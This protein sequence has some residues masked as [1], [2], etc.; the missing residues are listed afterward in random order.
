ML[1]RPPLFAA[2]VVLARHT[3]LAAI[4]STAAPAFLAFESVAAAATAFL[5]VPVATFFAVSTVGR[6]YGYANAAAGCL[7]YGR[8]GVAPGCL[9]RHRGCGVPYGRG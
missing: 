9:G 4:V 3:I 7:G 2:V 6:D 1:L 8:A 5:A